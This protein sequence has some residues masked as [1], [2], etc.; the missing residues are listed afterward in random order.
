[1]ENRQKWSWKVLE[2][3]HKGPGKSR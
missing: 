3:E 2:N 1:M